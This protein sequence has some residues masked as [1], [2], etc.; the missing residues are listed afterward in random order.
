M[1][2]FVAVCL[3]MLAMVSAT[4]MNF[5]ICP[6]CSD[7][8]NCKPPTDTSGLHGDLKNFNAPGGGECVCICG[9]IEDEECFSDGQC[10][11][12]LK[13]YIPS[14]YANTQSGQVKSGICQDKCR[15]MVDDKTPGAKKCGKYEECVVDDNG[16]AECKCKTFPCSSDVFGQNINAAMDGTTDRRNFQTECHMVN[17]NC[18]L[19]KKWRRPNNQ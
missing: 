6:D 19:S 7:L 4:S 8:P 9:K 3:A 18:Q 17:E 11:K 16:D 10:I 12:G 5:N 15:A 14:G 13:C 2:L 1:K